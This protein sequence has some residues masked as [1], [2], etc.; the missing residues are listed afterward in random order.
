MK[1]AD[2]PPE[3]PPGF[4]LLAQCNFCDEVDRDFLILKHD[5]AAYHVVICIRCITKIV[6]VAAER[7]F[8]TA[9]QS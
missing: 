2:P 7:F 6:D 9:E 8:A 5:S 3:A 4:V 1:I